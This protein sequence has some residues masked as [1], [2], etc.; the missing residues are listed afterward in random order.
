MNPNQIQIADR[1][2]WWGNFNLELYLKI[3]KIKH[4]KQ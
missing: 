1:L 3:C 4:E 2:K